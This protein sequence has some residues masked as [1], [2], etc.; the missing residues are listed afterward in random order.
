MKVD[1]HT[2]GT[3]KSHLYMTQRS[4]SP[5]VRSHDCRFSFSVWCELNDSFCLPGE[6]LDKISIIKSTHLLEGASRYPGFLLKV[7]ITFVC[8]HLLC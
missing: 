1:R 3:G 6:L 4:P 2:C 7:L 5:Q 8:F